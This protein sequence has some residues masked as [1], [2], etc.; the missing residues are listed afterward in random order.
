MVADG[1]RAVAL[2][3]GSIEPQGLGESVSEGSAVNVHYVVCLCV[4]FIFCWLCSLNILILYA[5]GAWH[6]EL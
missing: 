6:S 2:I 4:K 1:H 5:N 3:V